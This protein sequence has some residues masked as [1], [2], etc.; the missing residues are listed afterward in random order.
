M[1]GPI[2]KGLPPFNSIGFVE[3]ANLLRS[4]RRPLSGYLGGKDRAGY[5]IEKLSDAWASSFQCQHAIPCNSATSGLLAAC[6]AAGVGPDCEVW[7]TPY[8]MSATAACAMVLGAKV[9][10]VD[11]EPQRYGIDPAILRNAPGKKP[12]ALIVTNLFGHPAY[13][14]A[15]RS[16]CDERHVIMIEDNAQGIFAKENGKYA[17]TVGHMGVFSLNVH[18]HLQCGEGGVV[19]TDDN[20]FALRLRSAINHGELSPHSDNYA[21][22]NLRMTEPVAAIACAQLSK[23]DEIMESRRRL[24]RHISEMMLAAPFVKPPLIGLNCVHSFYVW[25]GTI[26]DPT[27][28]KKFVHELNLRGFPIRAGYSK[29]LTEVFRYGIPCRVTEQIEKNEIITFEVC[30]YDPK[31]HHLKRMRDIISYVAEGLE[32]PWRSTDGKSA[33]C[34]LPT[35]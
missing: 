19:C 21:G 35:S 30:G 31:F 9:K 13:L 1:D 32:R 24:A 11:I 5:W 2:L 29:P 14:H 7:T 8:S 33:G 16:W 3:K 26:A 4:L 27:L 6:M 25:A 10:F 28:R 20:T 15:I 22:L 17:G 34:N 12:R 18:K 23:A